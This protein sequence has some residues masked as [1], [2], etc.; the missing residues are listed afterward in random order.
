MCPPGAS[1]SPRRS[2]LSS[3]GPSPGSEN[4]KHATDILESTDQYRLSIQANP[5]VPMMDIYAQAP[6]AES[7]EQLANGAVDELR[8]YLGRSRPRG[9]DPGGGPD[10]ARPA[11]QGRRRGR[12]TGGIQWQVG[13]LAFLLTFVVACA[14]VIFFSRLR[15]GLADRRALRS[16]GAEG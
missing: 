1:R 14:T 3:R 11:R 13:A 4:Q 2:P 5:T 16:P 7:A 15:A 10:P 8:S 6:S 9:A 12:S